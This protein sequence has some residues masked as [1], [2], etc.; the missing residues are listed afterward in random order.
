[1][2]FQEIKPGE[3]QKNPF[4]MIGKEWLLVTAQKDGK[5]N[6]MTASWGG[7]G[8]MWGKEVA[9]LV[10]R[11]QRYTKEFIDGSETLSLCVLDEA[12]RKTLG[13]L[14]SVSGRMEDK[15]TK[16]GLSVVHE[17][18]TPYFEEA[19]T[20]LICK[21]LYAQEYRP[22]CFLDAEPAKKWYPDNDFHTMYIC[23]IQKV[24]KK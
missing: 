8:V 15:I 17:G 1:M 10:I 3:L 5:S 4:T 20:V 23:E 18:D 22:E 9:F 16:S 21:K 11:P 2:S 13:Y 24:L 7:V 6:T 12:Y 19:N 14:G